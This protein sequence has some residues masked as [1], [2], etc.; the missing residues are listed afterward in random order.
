MRTTVESTLTTKGQ[1]TIPKRIREFLH[2]NPK[3]KIAFEI[4]HDEVKIKH[5]LSVES[6]F[7]IVKPTYR[8]E[9]FKKIRESVEKAIAE[10]AAGEL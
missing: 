9:N 2:I 7:G 8:P 5:A 3:D 1:I 6:T 4:E 10:E